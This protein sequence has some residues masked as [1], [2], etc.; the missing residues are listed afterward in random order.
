MDP[1]IPVFLLLS[2]FLQGCCGPQCEFDREM[3]AHSGTGGGTDAIVADMPFAAGYRAQ[4]VQGAG[5]SY[6]HTYTSTKYD[7]DLDTPNNRN[8]LVFAPMNG[9][10]YVHDDGSG[11]F[12]RHV[13][14]D[15]H[16]GT[17][18]LM[19]HMK[20]IFIQSGTDVAQGQILGFEGTTGASTGDH[21]HYGRHSGNAQ[22]SASYGASLKGFQMK[23]VDVTSGRDVEVMTTDAVCALSG[24]HVYQSELPTAAWHPVG[25]LLKQAGDSLVFE[26]TPDNGLT[27]FMTEDAFLS[28]GFSFQDVALVSQEEL[29]CYGET[30]S[31]FNASPV[32]AVKDS[33]SGAWLL[34]GETTDPERKRYRVDETGAAG[35]LASYGIRASSYDDID[36]GTDADIRQYP[37]AGRVTYRTGSLLSQEG[38]SDVYVMNAGVAMPIRDWNTYLLM[39]F[40]DRDI[41]RVTADELLTNVT[42]KGNC[43]TDLYCITKEDVTECGH[44]EEV[45][46]EQQ[47]QGDSGQDLPEGTDSGDGADSAVDAEAFLLRWTTP[48]SRIADWITVAG[49][50]TSSSGEVT[51]WNPVLAETHGAQ[52]ITYDRPD[53]GAGDTFRFSMAYGQNGTESWSCLAPYP[54]GTIQGALDAKVNGVSVPVRTVADPES[55]GCQLQLTIP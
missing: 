42:N 44:S 34:I 10:A 31:A 22:K 24:G 55:A 52:M 17:Y 50:W 25:S 20:D 27:A 30:V 15:L 19:G 41:I 38:K 51:A 6:S 13:N 39:G 54:P 28:R 33:Q 36:Y 11:G 16:D 48:G 12:G 4:C 2:L 49:T 23:A 21:V 35:V 45:D 3:N 5:G 43:Q 37:N 8:D 46:N 1:K 53:A 7:L 32:R 47:S 40:G 18:L 29:A 26:R 9:T 14:L